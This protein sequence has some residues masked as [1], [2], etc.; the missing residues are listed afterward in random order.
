VTVAIVNNPGSPAGTTAEVAVEL[1]T[2][3]EVLAGSTRLKA[4]TVTKLVLNTLTMAS[5]ARLGRVHG[6]LMID[7][8][9]RSAKLRARASRLVQQLAAVSPPAARRA[10]RAAGGRVRVA[11]LI[12][13]TGLELAPARRLLRECGGSLRDALER[14]TRRHRL[15]HSR[16]RGGRRP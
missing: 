12:A 16:P 8:E 11:V 2:G 6:N 5:M 13:R 7:V 14:H 3:P 10:L 4:G 1:L 15:A 9:P